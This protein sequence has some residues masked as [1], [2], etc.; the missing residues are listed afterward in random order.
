M[1][2][3]SSTPKRAVGP[4]LAAGLFVTALATPASGQDFGSQA[5][6]LTTYVTLYANAGVENQ[7]SATISNDRLILDDTTGVA[8]NTC[9]HRPGGTSV[10]CGRA[11]TVLLLDIHM[12]DR[13][14][15]YQG[16]IALPTRVDAGLGADTVTTGSRDDTILVRD[17]VGNDTVS[18]G[19]GSDVVVGDV[20]DTI[21][22]DCEVRNLV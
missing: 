14:D 5:I 20:G 7:M 18:C 17:G 4:A 21:A 3:V 1:K 19:G 6:R 12:F 16:K 22:A 9:G 2:I 15:S 8:T 10:D 13:N 11:S